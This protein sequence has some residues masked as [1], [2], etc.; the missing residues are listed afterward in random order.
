MDNIWSKIKRDS[1]YQ[2][3]EVQD[4]ATYLE[5]VQS[6]LMEFD[7][8]YAPSKDLLVWYFY[9][10]LRPSIKLWINEESWELDD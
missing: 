7:A 1:Q 2:Q 6:I 8:K 9:E 10:G 5:H 3:E 4:W